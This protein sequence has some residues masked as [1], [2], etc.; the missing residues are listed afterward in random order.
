MKNLFA[1]T[2]WIYRSLPLLLVFL[3]PSLAQAHPGVAGHTHGLA[4]G[5]VH[6]ITGLDHICAMIAV[7]LWAAQ[8]GGRALW[9]VPLTFVSVMCIGGILG[10]SGI[11]IPFA[12]RGIA[13]SVLVLGVLIVA[14]VRLPLA[15]SA[16]LVGLFAICHGYAHGAEMPA[17]ASGLVYGLG[18]VIS[19]AT[20]HLS[21]I[22][23]GLLGRRIQNAQLIRYAGGAIAACG[24]YLC[25]V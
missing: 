18:F 15:V 25:C 22:G 11:A 5:L 16:L 3:L 20:L 21:G 7:G 9:L 13:V 2:S 4:N 19:T 14:A 6:P 1:R 8:R 12:E 10:M 23:L 24:L 17:A